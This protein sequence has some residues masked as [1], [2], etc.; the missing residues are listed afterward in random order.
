MQDNLDTIGCKFSE[1]RSLTSIYR[2]HLDDIETLVSY[3]TQVR[4]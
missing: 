4:R 2:T 3:A 1:T